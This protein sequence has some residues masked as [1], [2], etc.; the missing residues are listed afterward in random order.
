VIPATPAVHPFRLGD[1]R[2]ATLN[3]GPQATVLAVGD[4]NVSSYDLCGRP[5]A[6]VRGE[7]TFRRAL[8]GRLLQKR[9]A[10]GGEARVR[11]R[12]EAAEAEPVV[13]AARGEAVAAL[14][15]VERA[16]PPVAREEGVRRLRRIAAMNP[17]SLAAD[18]ARFLATYGGLVGI[19]PPDQYLSL[20]LRLTEG[21]SWNAC[22][23]CDFYKDVPFRV[24]T[25]PELAAHVEAVRAYF[26]ESIGLRRAVFLGDANALSVGHDKLQ[27]L[28]QAVAREFPGAPLYAFVDAM[29]GHRKTAEEYRAYAG[30]GLR[31][32]YVGLETGDPRLLSW[33]NKPGSPEDAV[34]LVDA[35]HA[36][37]LAAGVIV[38]L[39][40]GGERFAEE[41]T[42]R[43]AEVLTGMQLRSGD[44]LYFS[45]FV[46]SPRLEYARRATDPALFA[47]GAEA[48]AGQRQAILAGYRP[49]DP[50]RPPRVAAYDIR[51]FVY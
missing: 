3:L 20:V 44:L 6:L 18:A 27:P 30:R 8:D 40:A 50:T 24:K 14:A 23:F 49:A 11:R 39:G 5:F 22:T 46:D 4:E 7:G 2:G 33:L 43:T 16:L 28:V 29:T 41:H 48:C 21:C 37:G 45:E 1:G 47:L 34:A 31:R 36:A 13:E 10:V 17:P 26:G 15:V 42:L 9:P 38:L 12:L 19:L 32:V 35:L 51:E 25:V